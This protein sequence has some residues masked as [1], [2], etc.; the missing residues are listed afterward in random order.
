MDPKE[1][2]NYYLNSCRVYSVRLSGDNSELIAGCGMNA[3][4]ADLK[5]F[6]IEQ[7][8]VIKSIKAHDNDINSINYVERKNSAIFLSGSD[9]AYGKIW[10]VRALGI[11]NKPVG[12]FIGILNKN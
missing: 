11:N 5:I 10:D 12:Y 2:F 6:N 9:D 1:N 3:K 7:N 4:G 8:K